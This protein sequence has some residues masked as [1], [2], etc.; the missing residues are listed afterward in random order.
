MRK[1]RRSKRGRRRRNKRTLWHSAGE[2]G[3][4]SEKDEVP[5][6]CGRRNNFITT[7]AKAVALRGQKSLKMGV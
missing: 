1:S 7:R 3:P 4:S 5:K 2:G 6:G